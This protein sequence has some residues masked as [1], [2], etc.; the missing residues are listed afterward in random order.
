MFCILD[1]CY[2]T[3]LKFNF[4]LDLRWFEFPKKYTF[5]SFGKVDLFQ[6]VL[7]IPTLEHA[8]HTNMDYRTGFLRKN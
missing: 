1:D 5:C 4:F 8:W 3:K 6:T 7:Y 2:T